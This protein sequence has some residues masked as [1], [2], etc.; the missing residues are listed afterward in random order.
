MWILILSYNFFA[1]ARVCALLLLGWAEPRDPIN[2]PSSVNYSF[3]HLRL[4]GEQQRAY[5]Q[6]ARRRSSVETD[7]ENTTNNSQ[8]NEN[9]LICNSSSPLWMQEYNSVAFSPLEPCVLLSRSPLWRWWIPRTK[10]LSLGKQ[11]GMQ[12][13]GLRKK[14][15][16]SKQ[17]KGK[18]KRGTRKYI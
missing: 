7:M 10:S 8:K 9:I 3:I 11:E 18:A 5:V 12:S 1:L 13:R 16:S 4:V 14:S 17:A 15:S 2:Y 6:S